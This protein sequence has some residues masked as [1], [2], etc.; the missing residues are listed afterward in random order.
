LSAG[1]LSEIPENPFNP[2]LQNR[3]IITCCEPYRFYIHAEVIMNQFVTHS[4]NILPWDFRIDDAQ[5]FGNTFDGFTNDFKLS[6][7]SILEQMIHFKSEMADPFQILG[8]AL[9]C[10]DDVAEINRIISFHISP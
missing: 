6:N 4:G 1:T 3:D 10:I 7:D 5:V 2:L 9:R 8:N